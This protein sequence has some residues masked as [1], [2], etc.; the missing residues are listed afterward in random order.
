MDTDPMI[1]ERPLI[2]DLDLKS[3]PRTCTVLGPANLSG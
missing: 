2:Y 3:A 1:P